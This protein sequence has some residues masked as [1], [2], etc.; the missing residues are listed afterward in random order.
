M[1]QIS[2]QSLLTQIVGNADN[3]TMNLKPPLNVETLIGSAGGVP[4]AMAILNVARTTVL[5][6][7]RTGF[8]PAN[9]V[10]QIST[11]FGLRMEDVA[12]LARGPKTRT[13]PPVLRAAPPA[14]PEVRANRKTKS[15][16]AA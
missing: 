6:W 2:R 4:G 7:K 11:L 5:D 10:A 15:A 3:R 12:K 14:E 9:R 16:K 13:R 8:I 1:C